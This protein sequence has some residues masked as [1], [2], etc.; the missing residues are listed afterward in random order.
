MFGM[1]V[2]A[3]K[4]FSCGVSC[5]SDNEKNPQNP[6]PCLTVLVDC[7]YISRMTQSQNGAEKSFN[8]QRRPPAIAE[9]IEITMTCIEIALVNINTK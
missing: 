9:D 1:M 5:N 2:D 8:E 7:T 6:H 4:A 3:T